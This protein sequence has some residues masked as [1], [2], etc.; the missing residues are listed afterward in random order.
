MEKLTW[1]LVAMGIAGV[2]L[3]NHKNPKCFYLW[4]FTNASWCI[5]DWVHGLYS[6]SF[7]F[8]VYFLLAVHGWGK[9]RTESIY[10]MVKK[11]D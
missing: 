7:L 3:N 4:G 10:R 11:E 9:W 8:L 6:Q 5:W 1:A 2:I